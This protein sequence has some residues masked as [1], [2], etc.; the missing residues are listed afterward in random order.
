MEG[1]YTFRASDGREHARH[2][3]VLPAGRA[4]AGA[5]GGVNLV[6]KNKP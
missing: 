4:R 1:H 2:D 5:S 3:P 6:P